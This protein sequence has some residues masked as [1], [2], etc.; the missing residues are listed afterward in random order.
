MQFTNRPNQVVYVSRSVAVMV[1]P[2]FS[3]GGGALYVP[4][5]RRGESVSDAGKW[6]LPCGYL[7]WDENAR[8]AAIREAY[9]EIGLDLSDHL[10]DQP[11]FVQSEPSKDARQNVTL[12]FGCLVDV[13][14]LPPLKPSIEAPEVEWWGVT[15]AINSKD[16]AFNHNVLILEYLVMINLPELKLR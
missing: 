7:D 10:P 14:S 9:E 5:G 6:C 16:L 4:M 12:R 15:D 1:V 11:W 8:S 13:P 3:V 2:I